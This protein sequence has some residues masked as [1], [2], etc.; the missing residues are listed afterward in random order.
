MFILLYGPNTFLSRQQL[1]KSVEDFKK[2]RDP[3]GLN[4]N[5]F[6]AEKSEASLILENLV[7]SPFLAEKRLVVVERALSKGKKDLLDNLWQMVEQK[8][9]PESSVVIFW[10]EELSDKKPHPLS[11]WLKEQKYSKFFPSLTPGELNKWIKNEL[12]KEEMTME[13]LALTSLISHPLAQDL[14]R[15]NNELQKLILFAQQ[16]GQKIITS[17][18]L[19]LFLPEVA[20][21]N[22]FHFIDALTAKNSKQAV[23]LLQEQWQSGNSEPQVF[24]ALVWQFKTLLLVK[25]FMDLNPGLSSD[26]AAREL[27]LSPFVVK[28]AYG[29][30][31]NFSFAKLKEIYA[32][33][34]E[35]DKRAKTGE[36][37]YKLL[38]DLLVNKI[39]S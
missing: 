4:V 32:E 9:I 39:C 5:I 22:T 36:G 21:D 30:L 3:S 8:K 38:L 11:L 23:K 28:K 31:R 13:N 35:I 34:L 12:T 16:K 6:D 25:D 18:D 2:Q 27:A 20:D 1:K 29:V 24:G 15:L 10:E 19:N 14:W 33:L 17:A 37:D 7:A 26:V